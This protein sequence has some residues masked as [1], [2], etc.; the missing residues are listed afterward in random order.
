LLH[1]F[2]LLAEQLGAFALQVPHLVPKCRDLVGQC[3]PSLVREEICSSLFR[4]WVLE[5]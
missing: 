5:I 3:L 4:V 1:Q 2:T